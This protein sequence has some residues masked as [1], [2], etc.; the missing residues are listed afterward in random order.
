MNFI[1]NYAW[2]WKAHTIYTNPTCF[3]KT[4]SFQFHIRYIS[5]NS[6]NGSASKVSSPG[7]Q[8]VRE[9]GWLLDIDTS[10]HTHFMREGRAS[11]AVTIPLIEPMPASYTVL[12]VAEN[13]K[14]LGV[15]DLP[16]ENVNVGQ[17]TGLLFG[18]WKID[19]ILDRCAIKWNKIL[20]ALDTKLRV[21]VS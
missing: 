1:L 8:L 9:S 19:Q 10:S 21:S 14:E 2:P 18:L 7:I 15:Q 5:L 17:L 12:L 16:F 3:E 20:D 4:F 6:S 13:I 11:I